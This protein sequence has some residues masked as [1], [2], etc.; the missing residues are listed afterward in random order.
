M[1]YAAWV[2]RNGL[3]ACVIVLSGELSI[4]SV[5][6]APVVRLWEL[7]LDEHA[8]SPS[9][10]VATAARLATPL[11]LSSFLISLLISWKADN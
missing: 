7:G 1:L 4:T 3:N 10:T 9:H 2:A 6:A 5:V 8:A 11:R